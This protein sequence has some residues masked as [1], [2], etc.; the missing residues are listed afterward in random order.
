VYLFGPVFARVLHLQGR[1]PLHASTVVIDGLAVAF[2]GPPEAGKSTTAAKFAQLGYGVLGEDVL[3]LLPSEN[4][5]KAT[6]GYPV[7][8][9][10]PQSL[11]ILRGLPE[12][13]TDGT[14][15]LNKLCLDSRLGAYR[16]EGEPKA[17][18]AIYVLK[19]RAE[20][21]RAP[22]IEALEPHVALLE[23]LAN[24]L[25]QSV[26]DSEGRARNFAFLARLARA[27]PL[28][29]MIPHCNPDRLQRMSELIA[30]D[31]RKQVVPRWKIRAEAHV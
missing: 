1:T 2:L 21:E 3:N 27:V 13:S 11:E 24:I 17:L 10:W 31:F 30:E 6:P 12:I 14:P 9:L 4:E 23:L 22:Y 8:R 28:R 26:V 29:R 7:I 16:F 25:G 19:G 18:A 15:G 20:D 5:F